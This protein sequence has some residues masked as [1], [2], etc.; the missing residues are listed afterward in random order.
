[1]RGATPNSAPWFPDPHITGEGRKYHNSLN[2]DNCIPW[3]TTHPLGTL[4]PPPRNWVFAVPFY[5]SIRTSA[6]GWMMEWGVSPVNSMGTNPWL[7]FLCCEMSSLTSCKA[8]TSA[9]WADNA[10]R[11]PVNEGDGRSLP[12]REGKSASRKCV[13]PSE[14]EPLPPHGGR[15]PVPSPCQQWPAGPLGICSKP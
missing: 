5:L 2:E 4:N 3:D 1:M 6:S 11:E 8:G 15:S 12:G 13:Y 7:H 10:F 9:M 14:D